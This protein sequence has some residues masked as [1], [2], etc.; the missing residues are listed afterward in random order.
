MLRS[1]PRPTG[2][3]SRSPSWFPRCSPHSSRATGAS[4]ESATRGNGGRNDRAG[5]GA[6]DRAA[7]CA[8]LDRG[9][10]NWPQPIPHLRADPVR[11]SRNGQGWTSDPGPIPKPEVPDGQLTDGARVHCL[12]ASSS[13]PS[14]EA[15]S[16]QKCSGMARQISCMKRS[17]L[18]SPSATASRRGSYPW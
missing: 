14:S 15:R 9:P 16:T 10:D 7:H 5:V 6:E 2:S 17:R 12:A 4:C 3:R 8:Y 18:S 13:A 1:T 11:R